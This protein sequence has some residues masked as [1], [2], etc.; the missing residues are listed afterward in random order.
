[1]PGGAWVKLNHGGRV[2]MQD[3]DVDRWPAVWLVYKGAAMSWCMRSSL[4]RE[5]GWGKA[6]CK[7]MSDQTINE[8][9]TSSA[10]A[11]RKLQQSLSGKVI[12]WKT[13]L[14]HRRRRRRRPQRV[15]QTHPWKLWR[16]REFRQWCVEIKSDCRTGRKQWNHH[17]DQNKYTEGRGRRGEGIG[18]GEIAEGRRHVCFV[19]KTGYRLIADVCGKERETDTQR[20]RERESA[21]KEDSK[22][23]KNLN[24]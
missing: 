16:R 4:W 15:Q 24:A 13:L 21:V 22:M 19:S 5:R 1:M 3:K 14:V 20:E 7:W 23:G 8:A 2:W 18:R 6:W 11:R 17:R 10:K 9:S 12:T